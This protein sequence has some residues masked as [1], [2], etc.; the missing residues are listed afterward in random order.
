MASFDVMDPAEVAFSGSTITFSPPSDLDLN[1][2]YYVLIDATA[3]ENKTGNAFAGISLKTDWSFTTTTDATP[4]T[5]VSTN[6]ADEASGVAI[7]A[8]LVVTLNEN[9]AA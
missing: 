1:T 6:P 4:P 3:V 9:I 8:N 2:G 7:D 5:L